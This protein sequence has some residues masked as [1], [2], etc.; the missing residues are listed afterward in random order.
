MRDSLQLDESVPPLPRRPSP[1]V[2]VI[3]AGGRARRF[4]GIDKGLVEV[5]GRPMVEWIVDALRPQVDALLINA[6]RNEERYRDTG[7][8]VIG[9]LLPDFQGPLAGLAAA[10]A[11]VPP[12]GAILTV[13]CD[14]PLPPPMLAARLAGA[15]AGPDAELAV[16]HDGERLQ[17]VHALVPVALGE[18]LAAFLAEGGRKVET[19]YARHRVAVVDFGD[20]RG[21]FLNLNCLEDLTSVEGLVQAR[22][23]VTPA[24]PADGSRSQ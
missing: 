2:G 8:R 1:I 16:A 18:S 19:W 22:A 5:A 12:S 10:M 23:A 20:C 21:H 24:G 14:S 4:G 11:Q 17:L 7:L 13:P 9:D 15:L 3:L 6:N